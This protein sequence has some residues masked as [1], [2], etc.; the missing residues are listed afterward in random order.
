MVQQYQ[1][2]PHQ[3][4]HH[5]QQEIKAIAAIH[6]RTLTGSSTA[7]E[8]VTVSTT[9]AVHTE[10]R[11]EEET[12]FCFVMKSF[13]EDVTDN[14]ITWNDALDEPHSSDTSES[15]SDDDDDDDLSLSSHNSSV[16]GGNNHNNNGDDTNENDDDNEN[17]EEEND[18]EEEDETS[19]QNND[20]NLN[21]EEEEAYALHALVAGD[22]PLMSTMSKLRHHPRRDQIL[23]RVARSEELPL[24]RA[25]I[26]WDLLTSELSSYPASH[27]DDEFG[28]ILL[29]GILRMDPPLSVV[30]ETLR[31]FTKSCVDMK[32]FDVACQYA[33]DDVVRLV[34]HRTMQSRRLEGI[35]WDMLAFLGD[36]RIQPRHAKMLLQS[37]P[38]AVTDPGHGLFGVSP[39]DRMISGAFIHG[40]PNVWVEKLKLALLTAEYGLVDSD[41]STRETFF[42]FHALIRRLVAQDF[43]GVKFGPYS[44][45][46]TLAACLR[47][48]EGSEQGPFHCFD[49]AGYL[50]LHI[51]LSRWCNTN[52]GVLGERK[53]IKFLLQIHP[54]SAVVMTNEI[55]SSSS[56][57]S[58]TVGG[59]GARQ[60]LRHPLRMS[61]ENGW[62]CYDIIADAAPNA[63]STKNENGDLLLHIV[64]SGPYHARF[65]ITGARKIVKYFLRRYP[66]AVSIPNGAG[67][68]PLHL[69]L[70]NKW[71]CHDILM[72][73]CP[74][75]VE[76]RDVTSHFY[77][78]QIAACSFYQQFHYNSHARHHY[79][80]EKQQQQQKRQK[81]NNHH[82]GTPSNKKD[83]RE[84]SILYEL[85]R[86]AP[87]LLSH[88]VGVSSSTDTTLMP[89]IHQPLPQSSS[90]PYSAATVPVSNTMITL[91]TDASTTDQGFQQLSHPVNMD[92]ATT[93][94]L[95]PSIS[96]SKRQ[97]MGDESPDVATIIALHT[98]HLPSGVALTHNNSI[99]GSPAIKKR[100][101]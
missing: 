15:S 4:Y 83:V 37:I 54:Q 5:H 81:Q 39:L 31:L 84:L 14:G 74:P 58:S 10:E 2:P 101:I 26:D 8:A 38:E 36:A 27:V 98:Q 59:I 88:G 100:R 72:S 91:S 34:M 22:D 78:Y 18:A 6:Q 53:L 68:L 96:S 28:S 99:S 1:H 97:G 93:T 49:Y 79:Y 64:L 56:A 25:E 85:I 51:A 12:E 94:A 66:K 73:A 80:Q 70:E 67:K 3:Q 24:V 87:H 13:L 48:E 42:P 82:Q 41:A 19:E 52:L 17:Y 50:P 16:A 55:T 7:V 57:S 86:E 63:L 77:P 35:K 46:Q 71:P 30:R 62:P 9:A 45:V 89:A 76:T 43:M 23:F 90:N 11:K 60:K 61:I 92:A 69:A 32:S 29:Q 20:N 75:A 95:T 44:F 47:S 33:C 40:T 65:A 21:V